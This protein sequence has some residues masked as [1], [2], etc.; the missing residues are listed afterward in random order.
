[1]LIYQRVIDK[2]YEKPEGKS[3]KSRA[4][5]DPPRS[6]HPPSTWPSRRPGV[7]DGDAMRLI[8]LAI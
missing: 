1:M 8:E 4:I 2:P 5:W 6:W 7:L 3:R